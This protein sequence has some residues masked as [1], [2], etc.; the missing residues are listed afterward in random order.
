MIHDSSAELC[1]IQVM[2]AAM[3]GA[4]TGDVRALRGLTLFG[5][6]ACVLE[7]SLMVQAPYTAASAPPE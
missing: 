2:L 5:H 6:P 1:T 4:Y 3:V 7:L